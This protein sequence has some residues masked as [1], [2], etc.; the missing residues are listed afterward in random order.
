MPSKR[1]SIHL[2]QKR[3]VSESIETTLDFMRINRSV[4]FRTALT[5]LLPPSILV[6]LVLLFLGRDDSGIFYVWS[7]F[8][9]HGAEVYV[10]LTYLGLWAVYIHVYSLLIA[11]NSHGDSADTLKVRQMVPFF[12]EVAWRALLMPALPVLVLYLV[13]GEGSLWVVAL[14]LFVLLVP[15]AL[16]PSLFIL[17]R[18]DFFGAFGKSV[19]LGFSAWFHLAA[20]MAITMLLGF[21][22]T[23][24]FQVPEILLGSMVDT[25]TLGEAGLLGILLSFVLHFVLYVLVLFGALVMMSVFIMGCALEYGSISEDV[26]A[27]SL[28][29]DVENFE[30]L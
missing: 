9:D 2:Y 14:V 24:S 23:W 11:Y 1:H 18:R 8:F 15:L 10:P 16:M 3:S 20:V 22:I 19:S 30:N 7:E 6:S 4:W 5:I 25:F 26:E 21:Y 28:A 29:N 27:V 13:M 17:E 12:K